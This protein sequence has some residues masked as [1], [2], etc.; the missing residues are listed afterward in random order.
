M[1]TTAPRRADSV[2]VPQ[3]LI[4]SI[5]AGREW[6]ERHS[7]ALLPDALVF[8]HIGLRDA[9]LS[10]PGRLCAPRAGKVGRTLIPLTSQ[11]KA[12]AVATGRLYH[13]YRGQAPF[14]ELRKPLTARATRRRPPSA[15]MATLDRDVT[16]SALAE[17][18]RGRLSPASLRWMRQP[19]T[20]GFVLTH[21]L[22]AWL[23]CVWNEGRDDALEFAQRLA[24]RVLE[25]TAVSGGYYDLLAQQ[26]AFLALGAWPIGDLTPLVRDVLKSQDPSDGGWHYFDRT[27]SRASETWARVCCDRSPLLGWPIPYREEQLGVLASTVHH[28]HRGHAT[29]LSICALG[30][31]LRAAVGGTMRVTVRANRGSIP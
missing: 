7:D 11:F 8:A 27:L 18:T 22:L 19:H 23:L 13:G 29:G 17:A 25:E 14:A 28:A 26:T 16:N 9:G 21:Q 10:I 4:R 20:T 5:C 1:P 6:L 24:R 2:P 15:P 12:V 31:F 30:A 3:D